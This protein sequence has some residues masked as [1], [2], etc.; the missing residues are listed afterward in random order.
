MLAKIACNPSMMIRYAAAK[1]GW[2]DKSETAVTA[3]GEIPVVKIV[4]RDAGFPA[5]TLEP[6]RELAAE[7]GLAAG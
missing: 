6:S 7:A 3:K 2:G 5:E 1:L 4:E